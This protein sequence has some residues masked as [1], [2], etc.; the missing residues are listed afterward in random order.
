MTKQDPIDPASTDASLEM[1]H[2]TLERAMEKVKS[3]H[4]KDDTKET[5]VSGPILHMLIGGPSEKLSSDDLIMDSTGWQEMGLPPMSTY[6]ARDTMYGADLS[7]SSQAVNA[8]Q[9]FNEMPAEVL[10]KLSM[11]ISNIVGTPE[12]ISALQQECASLKKQVRSEGQ[13]RPEADGGGQSWRQRWT[14]KQKT[15]EEESALRQECAS[16]KN[17]LNQAKA[18]IKTLKASAT[19]SSDKKPE[20]VNQTAGD[21]RKFETV[22]AKKAKKAPPKVS[23]Q[24]QATAKANG[25]KI[26]TTGD[27]PSDS[28]YENDDDE[29]DDDERHVKSKNYFASA[30][31]FVARAVPAKLL[32]LKLPSPCRN[33]YHQ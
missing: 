10:N 30:R 6:L 15:P 18:Q 27:P 28:E 31:A 12:E 32:Q 23:P 5:Y 19:E 29:S 22:Q 3:V 21:K 11:E 24:P 14:T 2:N 7:A 17:Q 9:A 20:T 1:V 33:R 26:A 16:L 25:F 13:A 8:K 4:T